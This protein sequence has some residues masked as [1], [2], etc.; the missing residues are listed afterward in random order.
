MT[1]TDNRLS[2]ERATCE[3][4]SS[5]WVAMS[6]TSLIV[7]TAPSGRASIRLAESSLAT[8]KD[9][10][11]TLQVERRFRRRNVSRPDISGIS[12]SRSTASGLSCRTFCRAMRPSGAVSTTSRSGS[13]SRRRRRPFGSS[14]RCRKPNRLLAREHVAEQ[15]VT[16]AVEAHQPHL[17]DRTQ[18]GRTGLQA[19]A[20]QQQ[21]QLHVQ[22]RGLLHDVFAGEVVAALLEDLHHG[23]A[24]VISIRRII[25]AP[26]DVRIVLVHPY[27]P[28]LHRRI[29]AP[30]R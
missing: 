6:S 7:A 13:L 9:R 23:K 1:S 11:T 8:S 2:P 16:L 18:I 30:L 10:M 19:N 24:D 27:V 22:M 26:I 3:T 20:R 25:V 21:G 17:L 29:V 12:I 28:G 15:H 14:P 5:G 4:G